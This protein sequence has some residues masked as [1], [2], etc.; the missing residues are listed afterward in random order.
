MEHVRRVSLFKNGRS[1]AVRIPKEFELPGDEVNIRREGNALVI[2]PLAK[3]SLGELLKKWK[4]IDEE[5][6][7]I[8]DGPP[9]T[10]DL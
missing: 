3:P 4:N 8:S 7:E 1:Q 6:P 9:E 5:W 10:V 2:E